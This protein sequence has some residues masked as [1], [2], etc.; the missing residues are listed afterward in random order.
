MIKLSTYFWILTTAIAVSGFTISA[1]GV[2]MEI[3]ELG[4]FGLY[5]IIFGPLIA[6]LSGITA[7]VASKYQVEG[8]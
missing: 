2:Y 3:S 7:Q 6:S 5:L 8:R 4:P 1:F